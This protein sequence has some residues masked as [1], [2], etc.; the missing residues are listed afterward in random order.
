MLA[1]SF[2]VATLDRVTNRFIGFVIYHHRRHHHHS[3]AH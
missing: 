2:Q 3:Q 1:P